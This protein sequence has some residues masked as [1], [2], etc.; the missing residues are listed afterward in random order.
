MVS[1]TQIAQL[2]ADEEW[3]WHGVMVKLSPLYFFQFIYFF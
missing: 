1:D 2:T 3:V